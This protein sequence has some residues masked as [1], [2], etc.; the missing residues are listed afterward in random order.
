[1]EC[2]IIDHTVDKKKSWYLGIYALPHYSNNCSMP[3]VGNFYYP[4]RLAH[5][6]ARSFFFSE[7]ENI[8]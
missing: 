2:L 7:G 4:R 8:R 5:Y 3:Y 6:K 1:M